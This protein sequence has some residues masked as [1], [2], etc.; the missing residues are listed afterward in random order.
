M[1]FKTFIIGM[2]LVGIAIILS[3]LHRYQVYK[4]EIEQEMSKDRREVKH[5]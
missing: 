5:G 3:E 2:V 4:A 1:I